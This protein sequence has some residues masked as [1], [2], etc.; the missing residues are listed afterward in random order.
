MAG[1]LARDHMLRVHDCDDKQDTHPVHD[2]AR[3]NF[4]AWKA[5]MIEW[6]ALM[7]TSLAKCSQQVP[8]IFLV[9]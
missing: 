3:T 5:C 7:A 9:V 6:L 1:K 2:V 4:V 8:A